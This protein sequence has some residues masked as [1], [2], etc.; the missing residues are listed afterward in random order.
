MLAVNYFGG[1]EEYNGTIFINFSDQDKLNILST[2][3]AAKEHPQ[4][5]HTAI[6]SAIAYGTAELIQK[7]EELSG[8]Y[9][10]NIILVTDGDDN[11]SPS[12]IREKIRQIY[13]NKAINL[14]VISVG[15]EAKTGS[16]ESVA[17]KVIPVSSFDTLGAALVLTTEA[18]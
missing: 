7:Q 18:M 6:Y 14:F 5:G 12:E 9:V 1:Y 4:Y 16:L 10:R 13:P 3:L 17:D 11:N 15:S 2:M 8:Q